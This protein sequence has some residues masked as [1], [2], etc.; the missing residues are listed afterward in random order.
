MSSPLTLS[1]YHYTPYVRPTGN[2]HANAIVASHHVAVRK[3]RTLP[4]E[5]IPP[6]RLIA[7]SPFPVDR[8]VVATAARFDGIIVPLDYPAPGAITLERADCLRR[9]ELRQVEARQN[10][11]VAASVEG[12]ACGTAV[13]ARDVT[14]G[15][16]AG[17]ASQ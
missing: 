3:K 17:S 13:S 4:L 2:M 1:T 16:N 9:V 8:P 12:R 5:Q 15:P 14:T 11:E 7:A 10:R 6:R